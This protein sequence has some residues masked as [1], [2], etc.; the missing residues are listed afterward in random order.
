LARLNLRT[1]SFGAVLERALALLPLARSRVTLSLG[2]D[3]PVIVADEL[4]LTQTL[5][6]LLENAVKYSWSH[7][8]ITV[9]ARPE[10]H[11]LLISVQSH[12]RCIQAKRQSSLDDSE[13]AARVDDLTSR[14]LGLSIAQRLITGMGGEIWIES[15]ER[16]ATRV[17]LALPTAYG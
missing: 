3:I 8:P 6:N 5:T 4:W 16:S 13:G 11:R 10:S 14:G 17:V 7:S 2:Q 9:A 1:V 12:G 15:D